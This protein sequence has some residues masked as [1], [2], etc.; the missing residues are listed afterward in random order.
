MDA[1]KNANYTQGD[2]AGSGGRYR[3][4]EWARS[5]AQAGARVQVHHRANECAGAQGMLDLLYQPG[6]K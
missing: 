3:R 2:W 6:A 5:H 1:I 4:G